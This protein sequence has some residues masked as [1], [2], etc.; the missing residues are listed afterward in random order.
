MTL[1]GSI[2]QHN[3]E[4][5]AGIVLM[6]L[7]NPGIGVMSGSYT[8]LMDMRYGT[9]APGAIENGI[10]GAATVQLLR[11]Y[12][13]P[14][15]MLYPMTDSKIPDQQ[16]GYEKAFQLLLMALTGC[17]IIFGAGCIEDE[18]R[19]D[20]VQAVIDNEMFGMVG[21][22]LD[23]IMVNEDTLAIDLIDEVGP[24]PGTFLNKQHTRHWWRT[25][26]IYKPLVSDRLKYEKWVRTG[27]K[28]VVARARERAKEILKAHEVTPLPKDIEKEVE[29]ILKEC[30]KEKLAKVP[31]T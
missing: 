15:I 2:V 14:S 29:N 5:L 6:Q 4:S 7:V 27:S 11:H 21:R 23:G 30:E 8:Q 31:T 24:I 18:S 13:I 17:N 1:A 10:F 28:D 26:E 20:P 25:K 9:L 22:V 16:T 12:K 3:A 19:H